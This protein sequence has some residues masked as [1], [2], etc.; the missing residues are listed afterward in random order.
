MTTR[1]FKLAL[2]ANRKEAKNQ[3][4]YDG[5]FKSKIMPNKKKTQHSKYRKNKA[6]ETDDIG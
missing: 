5:R 6:N 2:A 3:G 4:F 1:L